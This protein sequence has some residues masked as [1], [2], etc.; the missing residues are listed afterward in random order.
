MIDVIRD[1]DLVNMVSKLVMIELVFTI[2]A[3]LLNIKGMLQ[4]FGRILNIIALLK[5]YK[6]WA[7]YTF[8]HKLGFRHFTRPV[9]YC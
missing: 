8:S 7:R 3:T 6:I 1:C 9:R 2:Y 5:D 4:K